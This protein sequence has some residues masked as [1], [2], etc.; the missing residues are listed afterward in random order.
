MSE[1]AA[2]SPSFEDAYQQHFNNVAGYAVNHG[3]AQACE[4]IAQ[5][6]MW[7]LYKTEGVDYDRPGPWLA[8]VAGHL[9]IDRWRAMQA[10][11]KELPPDAMRE[12]PTTSNDTELVL[13][14]M[15]VEQALGFM[16]DKQRQVIELLY[17]QDRTAKEVAE[18]LSIPASSVRTRHFYGLRA[19]HAGLKAL[20]VHSPE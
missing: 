6:A 11:P 8:T 18:M 2:S 12:E 17:M 7:R 13:T 4:D 5:E 1:V 9:I 14:R 19:A 3:A 15:L 16:S 20:D 10:R